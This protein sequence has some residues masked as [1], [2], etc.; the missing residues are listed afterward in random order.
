V[1]SDASSRSFLI[2]NTSSAGVVLLKPAPLGTNPGSVDMSDA[3]R[4]DFSKVQL[5]YVLE[6]GLALFCK[7]SGGSDVALDILEGGER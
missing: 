7:R 5:G 2:F 1:A 3:A 4:V 6:P